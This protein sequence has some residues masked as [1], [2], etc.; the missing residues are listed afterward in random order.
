[1][2][3]HAQLGRL[4]AARR[5]VGEVGLVGLA[6]VLGQ[7]VEHVGARGVLPALVIRA[8]VHAS[9]APCESASRIFLSPSRIR[10]FTVPTGA[11]SMSAIS[12]CVKPPKYASSITFS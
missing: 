12:T 4:G 10:P 5:A 7:R 3:G 6:L 2:R 11:S 9:T 8:H 1:M